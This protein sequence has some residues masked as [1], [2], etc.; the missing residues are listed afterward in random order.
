MS[1]STTRGRRASRL[2]ARGPSRGGVAR[3]PEVPEQ[4][5]Q[6]R[7]V[8][9]DQ[10]ARRR[11]ATTSRRAACTVSVVRFVPRASTARLRAGLAT[12]PHRRLRG[13]NGPRRSD[14]AGGYRRPGACAP[15]PV[16][17]FYPSTDG[18]ARPRT[19]GLTEVGPS[20]SAGRGVKVPRMSRVTSLTNMPEQQL[21]RW[22][23]RIALLFVVVLVAFVAFYAVDRF[24]APA[25]PIVD[26]SSP[27][28]EEAVA[29][30]P[31]RHRRP[32]GAWPTS[33]SR[34][35]ATTTR[36][37]STTR[38]SRPARRTGRPTRA[39][40]ARW[41]SRASSTRRPPTTTK[42][43]EIVHRRRDG[44][45]RLRARRCVLRPRV[46][47]PAAGQAAGCDRRAPEGAGHQADRR[48]HDV[49]P[50]HGLREGRTARQGRRAA[51]PGDR[52]RAG[53]L[54][55]AV[56]DARRRLHRDRRRRSWPSGPARWPPRRPATPPARSHASRR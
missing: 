46:D 37:P 6:L 38:S 17:Q 45:R 2:G 21:N 3:R 35:G 18:N 47:R 5:P 30:G 15:R 23:K 8:A 49:P 32:A 43:V 9:T 4:R 55:R 11:R 1:A 42:V 28:L 24:R 19:R 20:E 12:R 36:S 7:E 22:I 29:D 48:R 50:R 56:P 53:R 34:R 40:A 41:S 31:D 54:G 39:A 51:S 26:A 44:Q 25:P 10:P 14:R 33:T 16:S 52:V 27:I 13:P